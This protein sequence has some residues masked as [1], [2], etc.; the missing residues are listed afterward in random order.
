MQNQQI[1]VVFSS[2]ADTTA[3]NTFSGIRQVQQCIFCPQQL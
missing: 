2:Y 3:W 1:G